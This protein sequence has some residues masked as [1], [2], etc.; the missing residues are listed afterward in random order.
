MIEMLFA[1]GVL[2]LGSKM[3]P[4][5]RLSVKLVMFVCFLL[6]LVV[7]LWHVGAFKMLAEMLVMIFGA[8][9]EVIWLLMSSAFK[10]IF[11]IA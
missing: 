1:A 9:F 4:G 5:A 6:P 11:G 7:I 2:Y 10:I 3:S 8:I